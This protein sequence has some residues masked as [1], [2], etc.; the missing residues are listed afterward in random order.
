MIKYKQ[1]C[2]KC[3]KNYVIVSRRT[4]Y[5]VCYD[6]QKQELEGIIKDSQMKE[7]LD[8]PEEYYKNN[9]FLRSIKINYLKWGKL[10]E[11]QIEAFK[12]GIEKMK[13]ES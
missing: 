3:R 7:L 13:K 9:A 11:K 12:K 1:K 4:R 5:I 6:C 10:T 2:S 8:I